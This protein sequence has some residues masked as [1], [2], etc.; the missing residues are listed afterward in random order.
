MSAGAADGGFEPQQNLSDP[1]SLNSYS[2][3]E[4]DPIVKSDPSGKF[5]PALALP[6][7]FAPELSVP[8]AVP[9]YGGAAISGIV[10]GL[11]IYNGY[12]NSAQGAPGF[13]PLQESMVQNAYG[14]DPQMGG[15]I[16]KPQSRPVMGDR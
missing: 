2:Y 16:G 7:L 10:A 9:L 13:G 5:S 1:Q 8:A 3:F 11:A 4:D 15:P 12:N 6:F 14:S